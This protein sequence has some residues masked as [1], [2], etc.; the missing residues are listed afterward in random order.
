MDLTEL[1]LQAPKIKTWLGQ[2]TPHSR[3]LV[4]GLQDSA[5][6]LLLSAVLRA[7]KQP[8]LVVTN[9][10]FNASQL[11]DDLTNLLPETQVHLFPV[12]E[13]MAAQVAVSS[14]E[15]RSERVQALTF[16]AQ[17]QP[18]I[19][20]ASLAG[21]RQLLPSPD[22]WRASA[23]TIKPG[24]QLDPLQLRQQ[25]V[26]MG[27]TREQLVGRP[28]EFAMRGDIIDI[29]PLNTAN[30]VR[31]DLFDT[32][33]DSLRYFEA[34]SQRSI[35]N[36]NAFTL[37][38]ATDFLV[39]PALLQ[40]AAPRVKKAY[41]AEL[42]TLKEASAQTVLKNNLLPLITALEKGEVTPELVRYRDM[43]YTPAANLTTYL[44]ADGLIVL[45]DYPRMQESETELAADSDQW[46]AEEIAAQRMLHS[47]TSHQDLK[48][49]LR[50]NKHTHIYLTLFQK[51]MG[52]LRLD[53]ILDLQNRDM[54]QFFGQ[55]PLFKA[56]IDRWQAQ[57][58]TVVV[59]VGD[60][61]RRER[62]GNILRDFKIKAVLA[63]E[64]TLQPQQV[65]I[66][67]T[68]LQNG[69]ELPDAN[70]VVITEKELFNQPVKKRVRRQTLANAERIKSYN[71]L[72][73]GD[74]VVHV[75]HGIGKYVGM[76]TL[77]VDGAHQDY[78]TILY[79]GND[80][81]FIPVSQLNMVQ[82]YVAS[83]GKTPRINKLGGSEWAKTKRKVS[84]KIE[85]IADDLIELYAQREAEKGFAFSP[86]ND[87]QR[88]FEDAFPYTETADQ[89]RSVAE[90][91]HD[92]EREK[93]MDRL[94]VGDVGF[95]K[96]E[97]ALRA[98]FKAVQDGKQAAFLVPTTILAQQHFDTMLQRFADF[99][100]Q[101]E[102]LSRFRTTKQIHASLAAIKSGQADIVIGTHRILSK[103][104]DFHDLGL[105]VVDEEQ[106]FGVK[107]KERLKTLRANVDVL[108]MTA[109]P[110]PRTLNMSMVGVRDLSVIETPPANRYPVQTY[111]MEQN[112][113]ALRSGIQRELA[114]GGQV[115]YLHNRVEDIERTVAN[116]EALV[117]AA[118]VTYAHGQMTE[119]Q[120]ENT[121]YE[122]VHGQYDVIVTTTIIENGVNMPNVNTLF[123]EDADHMGLAQ[124]YQLR[125]RVG[126]S[127]RVGYAYFMYRQDKVLTEVSEKRLAAIRDFT[128]LGSGFKIAMRDL[129]IRGAGN[130]LGKQQHG[131]IDSVGYDLYSQ[132]LADA[133]AQKQGKVAQVKSD[134]EIDLGIEAYLPTEYIN[135]QRQKIELY[136]RVRELTSAAD[137]EE[138]QA[139][140]FDRFGDYPDA[141]A[142][143]LAI[144]LLKVYADQ[145]LVERVR[146]LDSQLQVKLSAQG[147]RQIAPED[148]F[149]ALSRTKLKAT[150]KMAED[151]LVVA[152]IIQPKMQQ[153]DW[154][155]EL[156]Q[157]LK[158]LAAIV[159]QTAPA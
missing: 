87:Y 24:G 42:A 149:K 36:L 158:G 153:A 49:L 40:Q 159:Q 154:L 112:A 30:P 121:L 71:E 146:H 55:M 11:V 93:P 135:D 89:L 152:L 80:K 150:V 58:Q 39:T 125:G 105:L 128:E 148:V 18:G 123:V 132:M 29:Y 131:F 92:M 43:I 156:T 38:P 81:L 67:A 120:M 107:A 61:E 13:V 119:A 14:P 27:Y 130:L 57:Q 65:Q 151:K 144:G 102:L 31:I 8:L 143:L 136:K 47:Q 157:F 25:L 91:K 110:I 63:K 44:P 28:G 48:G 88:E 111:V 118:S 145:A 138:L 69:F 21:I 50:K 98:I 34:G 108:T 90:I 141:V 3:Q 101:V 77:E 114:R 22:L 68:S 82:K 2:V 70:L 122:F 115:F 19:V 23:L 133:V 100:V 56:E 9:S 126:R 127:S 79:Q 32:E 15:Y 94:L 46:V 72:N 26:G 140:L 124:L 106:R 1:L 60:D 86:D 116:I 117:P 142:H 76:Q 6:S 62:V 10:L 104:V 85:D 33:V 7:K 139:D 103:D 84:S 5:R 64:A 54:Q 113:G 37:L 73:P 74:Y 35:E 16:L 147:T 129:S 78:I 45:D 99:P 12:D 51:G 20:V 59:M 83:E 52:N 134:A 17:Q 66:V 53:Q 4:T 97:V 95:G 137:L 41:Q 155:I 75:N 109:T 96:T